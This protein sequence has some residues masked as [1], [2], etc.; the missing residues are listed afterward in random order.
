M[1]GFVSSPM[2]S[3]EAWRTA[4]NAEIRSYADVYADVIAA[5]AAAGFA[6]SIDQTGGMCMALRFALPDGFGM[7]TDRDDT[8]S[9]DR[10]EWDG[11]YFAVYA[12]DD[13][14]DDFDPEPIACECHEVKSAVTAVDLVRSVLAEFAGGAA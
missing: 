3:E 13:Q 2:P 7:L 14:S 6:A 10:E 12:G 5:L 11:W 1:A 4:Y 8:L 9:Y